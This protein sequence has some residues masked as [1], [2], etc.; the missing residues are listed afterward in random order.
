MS[1]PPDNNGRVTL[2]I[3]NANLLHLTAEVQSLRSDMCAKVN[4]CEM[5]MRQVEKWSSTSEER[6]RRHEDDHDT[7]NTKNTA[8]D[9]I[10]SLA[11]AVA[12]ILIGKP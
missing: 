3:L 7:L 12:G 5:R 9:I 2:A 4:D 8:L 10:G 1:D 6:W 11:A